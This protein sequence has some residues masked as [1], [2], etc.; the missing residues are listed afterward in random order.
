QSHGAGVAGAEMAR[1]LVPDEA[2]RPDGVLH[3]LP[4]SRA[5]PIRMVQD[6]GD[7]ALGDP[8]ET[9]DVQDADSAS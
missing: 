7:S 4:P 2:Q 8:G 5:H 1:G 9:R 3:C 6:I